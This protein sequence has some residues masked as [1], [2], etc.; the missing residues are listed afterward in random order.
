MSAQQ[1]T[2]TLYHKKRKE[3]NLL[4]AQVQVQA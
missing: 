1:F 4:V 3:K 2:E